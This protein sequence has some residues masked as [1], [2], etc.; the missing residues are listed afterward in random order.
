MSTALDIGALD[1]FPEGEP[2][3]AMVGETAVC[4][5]RV[6]DRVY[7]LH[8]TCSHALE[9]LSGGWIDGHRLSCPRH[10]AEFDLRSGEPLTPPA[11]RA[12]P[13]FAVRVEDRRVLVDPTPSIPHP[14]TD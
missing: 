5:A 13:T 8:D 1:D 9:S 3:H 2:R 4:V 12:V 6:G 14:L 7:A 10:G 11:T